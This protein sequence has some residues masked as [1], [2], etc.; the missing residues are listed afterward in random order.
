MASKPGHLRLV[1]PTTLK[2]KVIFRTDILQFGEE[3][4]NRFLYKLLGRSDGSARR[5]ESGTT[6]GAAGKR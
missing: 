2:L 3:E 1:Q 4:V 5:R 6:G